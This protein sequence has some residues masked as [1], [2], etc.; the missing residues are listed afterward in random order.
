MNGG[1]SG[2]GMG[3]KFLELVAM[4]TVSPSGAPGSA[5]QRWKL[6]KNSLAH[7]S[8]LS[9]TGR[10]PFTG[11]HNGNSYHASLGD[12]PAPRAVP[13]VCKREPGDIHGGTL[14]GSTRMAGA[15]AV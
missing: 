14:P 15:H 5:G 10:I 2:Q 4:T 8:G 11:T 13:Q 12:I 1:Q 6:D 9:N 3:E 7:L